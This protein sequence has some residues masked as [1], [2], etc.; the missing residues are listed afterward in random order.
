MKSQI[1]T[2]RRPGIRNFFKRRTK[3][4]MHFMEAHEIAS[5]QQCQKDIYEKGIPQ[6]MDDA[7]FEKLKAAYKDIENEKYSKLMI[8]DEAGAKKIKTAYRQIEAKNIT[9]Q[10][11]AS[12][13]PIINEL[14][15]PQT[16]IKKP[17]KPH[18]GYVISE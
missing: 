11:L 13:K 9:K 8:I 7:G 2:I 4:N 1:V 17:N 16:E 14:D 5:L 6:A 15:E 10:R 18:S 3:V 12:H